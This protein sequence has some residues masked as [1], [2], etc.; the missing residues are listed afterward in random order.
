MMLVP[1]LVSGGLGLL[2]GGLLGVANFYLKVEED[3]RIQELINMLPGYNCGSCGFP[4]CSGLA[5]SIVENG[6]SI[7]ACK[8]CSV[9]AKAKI[10]EFLNENKK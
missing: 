2:L 1:I 7:N 3:P 5:K 4:G 8:P 10:N 6:N 9:D